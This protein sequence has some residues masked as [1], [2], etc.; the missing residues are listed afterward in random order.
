MEVA[1]EL[2]KHLVRVYNVRESSRGMI[3]T[4]AFGFPAR[5]HWILD[6]LIRYAPGI[7]RNIQKVTLRQLAL[8]SLIKDQ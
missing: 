3:L 2:S 7:K 4:N 5:V 6:P 8:L 1:G